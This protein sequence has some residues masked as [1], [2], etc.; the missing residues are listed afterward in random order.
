M[1]N[2]ARAMLQ[3][4]KDEASE[5]TEQ[6]SE[7][8]EQ[9][10]GVLADVRRVAAEQGVSQQAI[11]FKD[12]AEA[13]EELAETWRSRTTKLAWGLGGYALLSIFFHKWSWLQPEDT[14]QSIQL[15]TSKILIFGVISYMLFLSA[16]NFLSH[17]HSAIINKHRQNALMTYTAI[18]DSAATEESKD[19]VL[20]HASACIFSP[21]DTGFIKSQSQQ[22]STTRSVVELLPKTTMKLD[23][24]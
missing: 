8:Q 2:E 7:H 19:V 15:V 17:K 16:K 18:T 10:Q 4:V 6:L 21:Q 20:N 14:I 1:E 13:H 22:S 11:Y 9:A 24:Q 5:I 3:N 12:E 23:T